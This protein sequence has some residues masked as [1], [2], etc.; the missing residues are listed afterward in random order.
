MT[1]KLIYL[2]GAS[3]AGKD[4][5]LRAIACLSLPKVC[6]VK[7]H[8]TRPQNSSEAHFCLSEADFLAKVARSDFAMNWKANG[9]HYGIDKTINDELQAGKSVIVNGSRAYLPTAIKQY[10]ELIP[11]LLVV[12]Q[13]VLLQRLTHRGREDESGIKAR[14]ARNE[15]LQSKFPDNTQYLDNNG[16]LDATVNQLL[17]LLT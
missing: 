10:P 12:G 8:I 13:A 16:T 4:S 6:I 15:K 5:L 7:R 1:G 2:M 9:F 14:L 11:A 17:Q 3:G